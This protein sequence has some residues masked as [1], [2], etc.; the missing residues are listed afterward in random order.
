MEG[1]TTLIKFRWFWS[2]TDLTEPDDSHLEKVSAVLK[3]NLEFD[4]FVLDGNLENE[5]QDSSVIYRKYSSCIQP[6][7]AGST[8]F[9]KKR[10]G[11][12]SYILQRRTGNEHGFQGSFVRRYCSRV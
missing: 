10:V 2:E 9:F 7:L 5:R 11:L 4:E 8:S 3:N 6:I 12:L 1:K